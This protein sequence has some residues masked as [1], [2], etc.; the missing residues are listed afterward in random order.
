MKPGR[1]SHKDARKAGDR[2]CP[3]CRAAYMREWRARR[4]A[5]RLHAVAERLFNTLHVKHTD[6]PERTAA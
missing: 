1:C 5:K 6:T 4:K 2:Y 3:A